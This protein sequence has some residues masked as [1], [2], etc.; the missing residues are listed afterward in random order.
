MTE[1]ELFLAALELDPAQRAT[2]LD[3]ACGTDLALRL[4][5]D[6]LLKSHAQAG[7]FLAKP[8]QERPDE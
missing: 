2:Y 6:Q 3:A 7:N 8:A 5:L 4:R 1:R